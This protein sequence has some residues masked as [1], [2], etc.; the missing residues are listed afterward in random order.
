[1]NVGASLVNTLDK[2]LDEIVGDHPFI[3]DIADF[4]GIIEEDM[5]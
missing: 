1:M 5:S 3:F 2:G 4:K